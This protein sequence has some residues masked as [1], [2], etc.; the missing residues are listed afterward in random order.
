M[1]QDIYVVIEHLRGQ[2]AEISYVMLAAARELAKGQKGKVVAILLGK[3]AQGL[4]GNL[5]ADR[6]VSFDHPA[7]ADFTSDAYQKVLADLIQKD[8]PRAVLFGSTSIGTDLAS[9][10]SIRLGLPLVSSCRTFSPEGKFVSQICGGKIMA[11]GDL[12]MPTALITVVP[13]GYKA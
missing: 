13:G 8:Q 4:A 9:V 11:E 10:L 12:P 1:T 5:A 7:L 6:L 2:V 3:N